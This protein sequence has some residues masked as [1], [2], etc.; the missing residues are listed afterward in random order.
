ML[1]RLLKLEEGN[2]RRRGETGEELAVSVAVI[3]HCA[4]EEISLR[5]ELSSVQTDVSERSEA[6]ACFPSSESPIKE[7]EAVL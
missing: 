6:P 2:R 3:V 1:L 4:G 5:A 7:T